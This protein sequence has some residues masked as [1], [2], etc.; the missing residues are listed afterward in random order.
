MQFREEKRCPLCGQH[1]VEE[2]KIRYSGK[3]DCLSEPFLLCPV[4]GWKKRC[5]QS[6]DL[7]FNYL[8]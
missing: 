8:L 7:L 5:R 3:N 6:E 1:L 2:E 4:C